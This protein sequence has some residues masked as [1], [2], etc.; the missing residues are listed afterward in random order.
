M[1]I[2]GG[3]KA[4]KDADVLELL[5]ADAA[6]PVAPLGPPCYVVYLLCPIGINHV[7]SL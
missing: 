6:E 4:S 3:S 5:A 1:E 7:G 2:E